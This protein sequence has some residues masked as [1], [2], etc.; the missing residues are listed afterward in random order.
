M[1]QTKEKQLLLT[2]T[3]RTEELL[4]SMARARGLLH[5]RGPGRI[6]E[7]GCISRLLYALAQEWATTQ[8]QGGDTK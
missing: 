3:P 8:S 4:R 7:R 6:T 2:V 5:K 1:K